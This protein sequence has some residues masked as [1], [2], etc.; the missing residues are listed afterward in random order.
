M[1]TA[2]ILNLFCHESNVQ[3]GT[4]TG[5]NPLKNLQ[6]E[7]PDLKA[8]VQRKRVLDFGCGYGDQSA[9]LVN[10]YGC[11]ATGYDTNAKTLHDARLKN[12]GVAEFV[13]RLEQGGYDV[14]ISQD[15]MEHFPDPAEA[16]QEMKGALAPGGMILITFGPPW[17]APYGSH[18]HFFCR[19]PWLNLLVPESVVM[20]VRSLYR[21]DGA[22]R[23]EEVESGL[24][25][26]T[27]AKFERLLEDFGLE[28]VRRRYRAVKGWKVLTRIPILRELFTSHVTV[29]L[30]A[31]RDAEE[32]AG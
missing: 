10:V 19:I 7:Y 14:V 24:N 30:R 11:Q 3:T 5:Q 1:I 32:V 6:Y 31:Q 22:R 12:G 21:N 9:A 15:A 17:Y 20:A 23:Y 29:L 18:M 27:V 26:M 16:L 25:R 2:R 8:L 28:V 4:L 13:D